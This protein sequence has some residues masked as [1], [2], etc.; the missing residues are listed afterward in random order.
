MINVG[1]FVEIHANEWIVRGRVDLAINF[2]TL[3][4]NP[5]WYIELHNPDPLEDSQPYQWR[6]GFD[7]GTV[8]TLQ[9]S[10]DEQYANDLME[11]MEEW[12]A[13]EIHERALW[14]CARKE[15]T[16]DSELYEQWHIGELP[17]QDDTAFQEI[18]CAAFDAVTA[19]HFA[20]VSAIVLSRSTPA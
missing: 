5:D 10:V 16:I 19:E 12:Y 15:P 1:D 13:Q 20:A 3:T 6:Q 8:I 14:M 17:E 2:S 4:N 9:T 18:Y 7:G 11:Q